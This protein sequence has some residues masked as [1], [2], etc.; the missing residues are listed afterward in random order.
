M[1]IAFIAPG[2]LISK[3]EATWLTLHQLARCFQQQG[4]K[5]V[6]IAQKHPHLPS[7][8]EVEG[9]SVYRL[10]GSA[11]PFFRPLFRFLTA[12]RTLRF[13]R[14]QHFSP[15][16][17]HGFS[18]HPAA[19]LDSWLAQKLVVRKA[20]IVHSIKSY[21]K[22]TVKGWFL[23]HLAQKVTFPTQVAREK[24]FPQRH[25]VVLRSPV[26]ISKFQ[27]REKETLKKKYGYSGETVILYYGALRKEKGVDALI[28]SLP[29]VRKSVSRLRVIFAVRS[30]EHK[31]KKHYETMLSALG[32]LDCSQILLTDLAI[33]EYVSMADMVV[34]AYPT[35]RGTE[36]NP[37]CLLES[38]ASKTPVVTTAL[39]ELQEI[40][41]G[42]EV[43]FA[44]PDNPDS[45]AGQILHLLTDKALC[46]RKVQKAYQKSLLFGSDHIA[47]QLHKVYK[48]TF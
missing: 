36:G 27:P 21:P 8:E 4:H 11:L 47:Q 44:S 34:L 15:D 41:S 7:Y 16:I 18:S 39:P 5:V 25:A 43:Y 1:N 37:S 20:R 2:H 40:V 14:T 45:V 9:I 48:T 46:Q 23:L 3:K 29:Q 38:M 6:I 32:C 22:T 10:Y 33:E 24:L 35:L 31:A 26:N 17:I 19:V 13:L 30:A 42:E 28:A 12:A